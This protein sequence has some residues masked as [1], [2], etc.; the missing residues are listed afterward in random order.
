MIDVWYLHER[1]HL[2]SVC[3]QVFSQTSSLHTELSQLSPQRSHNLIETNLNTQHREKS[4][5]IL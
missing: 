3:I 2:G 1:L 4:H 5:H